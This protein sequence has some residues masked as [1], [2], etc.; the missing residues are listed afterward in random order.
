MAASR[1]RIERGG[2]LVTVGSIWA[3]MNLNRVE[4]SLVG[5]RIISV[6]RREGFLNWG[7]VIPGSGFSRR[8]TRASWCRTW[9]AGRPGGSTACWACCWW[10]WRCFSSS[11]PRRRPRDECRGR[12]GEIKKWRGLRGF[13]GRC[14]QLLLRVVR[15][16]RAKSCNEAQ[17]TYSSPKDSAYSSSPCTMNRMSS[18]SYSPISSLR[19]SL[20]M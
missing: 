10:G 19:A 20:T 13:H 4:M 3:E 2:S 18:G 12:R 15:A 11:T 16:I 8:A 7:C 1:R 17:R 9:G 6:G 5:C 14:L